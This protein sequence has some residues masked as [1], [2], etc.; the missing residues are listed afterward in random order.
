MKTTLVPIT[1]IFIIT[2][3]SC[4]YRNPVGKFETTRIPKAPDYSSPACWAALPN[5]T[6]PSDLWAG[7][8]KNQDT[9]D[10]ADVFYLSP[11]MYT[12]G[13]RYQKRWNATIDEVRFNKVVD[14]VAVKFQASIFNGVGRVYAPYYRQAHIKC[15]F[16]KDSA[17]TKKAF[18]VAY[19][20]V[21]NA[22]EYYLKY[23]N[24]GRPIII[25]SHSQGTT[26]AL[27]LISEFFDGK[28]LSKKLVVAY[29]LGM[30]VGKKQFGSIAICENPEQT[31]C[32]CSWRTFKNDYIPHGFPTGN[33]IAVVNPL[34][35]KTDTN[36]APSAL[37]KGSVFRNFS[38]V[39]PAANDAQIHD[40]ILW[41]NKPKFRG[42]F[43]LRTKNYH[44][45]DFNIFYMNIRENATKRLRAYWR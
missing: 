34:T 29:L 38:K 16:L 36:Y 6:D 33:R 3:Q 15:Y 37:N 12:G 21:R 13:K 40:G 45:G 31:N 22:F 32:F 24:N 26:H 5:K 8:V 35:W 14:N 2:I 9:S 25:A 41:T 7:N 20:D 44:A 19:R 30:P 28:P 10:D 27:K 4:A 1:A 39:V 18:D 17:S 43:F 42:S 11:T 23:Y